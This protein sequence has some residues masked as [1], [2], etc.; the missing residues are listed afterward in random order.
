MLELQRWR[1]EMYAWYVIFS[2]FAEFELLSFGLM[3]GY[4]AESLLSHSLTA[5]SKGIRT[6]GI[7]LAK[8]YSTPFSLILLCFNKYYF[9]LKYWNERSRSIDIFHG[10]TD[11]L[12][13]WGF[14]WW[15]IKFGITSL[16]HLKKFF[17]VL[18]SVA[19][20][21]FSLFFLSCLI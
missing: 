9:V 11:T 10:W 19:W 8:F 21:S 2:E 1:R 7:C 12:G 13:R 18:F 17:E 3:I 16:C 15:W 5:C 4:G 6:C 20:G 14:G